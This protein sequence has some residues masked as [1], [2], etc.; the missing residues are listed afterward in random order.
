MQPVDLDAMQRAEF[1][2]VERDPHRRAL[3]AASFRGHLARPLGGP[4]TIRRAVAEVVNIAYFNR[5]EENAA[6][7][8]QAEY[9]LFGKP[10]EPF[11]AH[12]ISR[13]RDFEQIL[14]VNL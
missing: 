2:M 13:P 4:P 10:G 5:L 9:L 11:L 14:S 6:P 1:E 3:T 7:L 12:V 8:A